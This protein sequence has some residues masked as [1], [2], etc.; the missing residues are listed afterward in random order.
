MK[1]HLVGSC[2]VA[3]TLIARASFAEA[4]ATTA[5]SAESAE[6]HDA[7]GT[8]WWLRHRPKAWAVEAGF[9]VGA[10][11]ISDDHN[12]QDLS[13]V[14]G[15]GGAHRT[16][17]TS[18]HWGIHAAVFPTTWAGL[19]GEFGFVVASLRPDGSADI[20]AP[21]AH[22]VFQL[23]IARVV[24]FAVIG[25][26]AY[27]MTD[28]T[29]GTDADPAFHFGAGAKVNITDRVAFRVDL[30]DVLLQKNK[31]IAGTQ[32]GDSVHNGELLAGLSLTIGRTT[33]RERVAPPPADSDGNGDGDGV[34]DSVDRCPTVAARTTDGCP[35]PAATDGNADPDDVEQAPDSV[36][37]PE[38]P[39]S[40]PTT[41]PT[42]PAD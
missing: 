2:I 27:A 25:G 41:T 17:G 28:S 36:D 10:T 12:L 40:P 35:A 13:I 33:E 14:T 21:R 22:V 18:S 1:A 42:A 19:E 3:S 8:P 29:M 26:G 5:S 31:L 20:V 30:R 32:N 39:P 24:P 7:D 16:F 6:E 9:Y 23:P 15:P 38:P 34:L 37:R 4:P 11:W